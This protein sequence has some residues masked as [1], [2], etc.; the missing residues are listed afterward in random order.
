ME[1]RLLTLSNLSG[2]EVNAI[3]RPE[4]PA[5]IK[6][7]ENDT[8]FDGQKSQDHDGVPTPVVTHDNAFIEELPGLP[9]QHGSTYAKHK[10]S[11]EDVNLFTTTLRLSRTNKLSTCNNGLLAN[12]RIIN[13]NRSNNAL[14][15]ISLPMMITVSHEQVQVVRSAIVSGSCIFHCF[16]L[17]NS[18]QNSH[19]LS[20]HVFILK[21]SIHSRQSTCLELHG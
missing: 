17:F 12:T 5:D 13:H 15:S 4:A 3:A 2:G 8:K 19:L 18:L 16:L 6:L 1:N 14:I 20:F 7:V 11:V 21:R 10:C 9:R